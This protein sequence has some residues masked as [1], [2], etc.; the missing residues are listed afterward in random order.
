MQ[1]RNGSKLAGDYIQ[2]YINFSV[3]FAL[4]RADLGFHANIRLIA[5]RDLP[6]Q[7]VGSPDPI[8]VPALA[9]CVCVDC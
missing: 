8:L 4:A 9:A 5:V 3:I 7:R 6:F 1:F 2:K